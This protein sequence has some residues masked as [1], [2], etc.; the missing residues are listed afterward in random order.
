MPPIQPET[1]TGLNQFALEGK[2]PRDHIEASTGRQ[3]VVPFR[4]ILFD[5][6]KAPEVTATWQLLYPGVFARHRTEKGSKR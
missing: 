6:A 5:A 4:W 3:R 1:E 2:A